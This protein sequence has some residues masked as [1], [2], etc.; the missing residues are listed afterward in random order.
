M[1]HPLTLV[2]QIV[3]SALT[4]FLLVFSAVSAYSLCAPDAAIGDGTNSRISEASTQKAGEIDGSNDRAREVSAAARRSGVQN[5]LICG[6]DR[7]SDLCDVIL[8]AQI[9]NIHHTASLVQIPRDT[10][11][12]YPQD[13]HHKLNALPAALGGMEAFS[14]FLSKALGIP[15]DHYALVDLDCIGDIVDAIGGVT[16]NVPTDMDYDDHS[17]GLSI[18]LKEG[19]QTLNGDLAEQF[20]RFR[21]GYATADL[22]RLDAQKLFLSAFLSNVKENCTLPTLIRIVRTLYGRVETD[23]SIGECVRLAATGLKLSSDRLAMET[24]DGEAARAN[25]DSGTS[26]Y[27]LSR[28]SAYDTVNR[29][30]NPFDA[31][32]PPSSFDPEERFTNRERPH[33][34]RIYRSSG[35]SPHP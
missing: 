34:D 21:A 33:L 17:Q 6:K 12:S 4:V 19:T 5:F 24:L 20:I 13:G 31:S 16:L 22:G 2:K 29:M 26:Y 3:L 14:G 15:I 11:T 1:K 23:L 9:D 27:I 18:H 7:A 32:L 28:E 30:L 8:V 35:R 10:Y 25:G